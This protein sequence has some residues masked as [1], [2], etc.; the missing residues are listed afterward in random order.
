METN[1]VAVG[2]DYDLPT[3]SVDEH[4]VHEEETPIETTEKIE[5]EVEQQLQPQQQEAEILP[6]VTRSSVE[7][8]QEEDI[9]V[10]ENVT[11]FYINSGENESE[12]N[13][14]I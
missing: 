2:T 3:K 5:E 9:L 13:E 8:V 7:V 14:L 10:E 11:P 4:S 12:R 1:N 6:P